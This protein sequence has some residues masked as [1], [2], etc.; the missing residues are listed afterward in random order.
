MEANDPVSF[1]LF[2]PSPLEGGQ[3]QLHPPLLR[4][5]QRGV[6][7]LQHVA[8]LLVVYGVELLVPA[9]ECRGL[10][11]AHPSKLG[12]PLAKLGVGVGVVRV[13]GRHLRWQHAVL[14]KGVIGVPND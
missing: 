12:H 2:S 4:R 1:S 9:L 13:G 8:R 11:L 5:R 6:N 3:P 14:G 10:A 7:V